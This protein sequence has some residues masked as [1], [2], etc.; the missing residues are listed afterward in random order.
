[1]NINYILAGASFL[2]GAAASGVTTWLITKKRYEKKHQEELDAVWK[3]ISS[4]DRNAGAAQAKA[5]EELTVEDAVFHKPDLNEYANRIRQEN[6]TAPDLPKTNDYIY[7]I[8]AS[9]LDED[10]Y[11]IIELVLYSDG[12]L[13]DD[14]DFPLSDPDITVGTEYRSILN[15]KD[16]AFIRNE[17]TKIDYDIC[18]SQLSFREMLEHNPAK[19]QQLEYN[20]AVEDYYNR[21]HN[22]D[23]DDIDDD[24]K[25]DEEDDDE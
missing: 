17:K 16:E 8:D 4:T 5:A 11:Q 19:E 25:D 2:V 18:R 22:P 20:D 1:M 13:A 23:G 15:G 3:D 10:E 14:Q 12:V 7:E 21:T 9:D 6:Y 24:D